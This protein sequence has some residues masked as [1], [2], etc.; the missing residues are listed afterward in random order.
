M[1]KSAYAYMAVT[2][3]GFCSSAWSAFMLQLKH[4][5]GFTFAKFLAEMFIL[6]GKVFITMLN[7]VFTYCLMKYGFKDY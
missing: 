2:G 4:G 6:V 7:C 1:N 5:M 3:D